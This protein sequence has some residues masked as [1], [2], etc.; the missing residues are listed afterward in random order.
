MSDD[1]YCSICSKEGTVEDP[2]VFSKEGLAYHQSCRETGDFELLVP[3]SDVILPNEE[4]LQLVKELDAR[5]LAW[6]SVITN[7]LSR[8][9]PSEYVKRRE[10][11]RKGIV[12]YVAGNYAIATL[13]ALSRL[14]VMNSFDVLQTDVSDNEVEC[15]GKLTLSFYCNGSWVDCWKTQWGNSQRKSGVPLGSTKKA[16]ATD[17]QKKC[18]SQ[19]GWASEVYATEI[20]WPAPPSKEDARASQLTSYYT[21]AGE[22][23]MTE[24]EAVEFCKDHNDSKSP[25]ELSV[26]DLTAMKRKIMK[27]K[28][29]EDVGTDGS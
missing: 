6:L 25:E 14:G 28:E 21:R 26:A 10:G 2:I 5:P 27:L 15:L 9:V 3:S 29:V 18:L 11:P 13:S 1:K 4:A 12:T 8:P 20:E 22:R 17:A 16:A 7:V 24:T 19:F 23:G